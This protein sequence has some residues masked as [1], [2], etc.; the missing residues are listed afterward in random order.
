M[1]T[2]YSP[3]MADRQPVTQEQAILAQEALKEII[4][5]EEIFEP[6]GPTNGRHFMKSMG[7][8]ADAP[9]FSDHYIR[10]IAPL[11]VDVTRIPS[12]INGVRIISSP[13]AANIVVKRVLFWKTLTIADLE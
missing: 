5:Y 4:S 7:V 3:N 6:P 12:E 9:D 1:A 2:V 11:E 8:T 10:F 13:V